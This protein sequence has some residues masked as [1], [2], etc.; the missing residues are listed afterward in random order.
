MRWKALR[1]GLGNGGSLGGGVYA[2]IAVKVGTGITLGQ[3]PAT[4]A[5]HCRMARTVE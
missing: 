1:I 2:V 4:P 5:L 3:G